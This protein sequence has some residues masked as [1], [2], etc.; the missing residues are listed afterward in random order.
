MKLPEVHALG[1]HAE[2]VLPGESHGCRQIHLLSV[3]ETIR[4]G[5][6]E[7]QG[8]AIILIW[9]TDCNRSIE[10]HQVAKAQNKASAFNLKIERQGNMETIIEKRKK[11]LYYVYNFIYK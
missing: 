6:I 11:R 3:G 5:R 1:S 10:A 4:L 7:E 9:M 8:F 2:D